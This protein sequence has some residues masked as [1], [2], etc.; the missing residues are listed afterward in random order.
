MIFGKKSASM[1]PG[2]PGGENLWA[3]DFRLTVE[4]KTEHL[5]LLSGQLQFWSSKSNLNHEKYNQ[6]SHD[7]W[8]YKAYFYLLDAMIGYSEEYRIFIDIKDTCGGT[9]VKKLQEVLC[10]NKY[11]FKHEVIRDIQQIKSK[12]FLEMRIMLPMR[13]VLNNPEFA[14]L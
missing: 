13:I 12:D 9:K 1:P 14:S 11:D 6:G 3:G 4:E 8:Y 2:Y 5:R 10:N 7:L